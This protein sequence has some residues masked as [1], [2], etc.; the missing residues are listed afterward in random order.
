MHSI[1]NRQ[2]SILL[3]EI[4]RL[5]F[6]VMKFLIFCDYFDDVKQDHT[7]LYMLERQLPFV[8]TAINFKIRTA[9]QFLCIRVRVIYFCMTCYLMLNYLAKILV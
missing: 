5:G 1:L 7:K 6:T 4:Q 9:V 3:L 2:P 8:S